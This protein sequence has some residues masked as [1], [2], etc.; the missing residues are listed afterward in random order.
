MSGQKF[1]GALSVTKRAGITSVD[2]RSCRRR[3]A[4]QWSD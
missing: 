4:G 2:R 3:E 1:T